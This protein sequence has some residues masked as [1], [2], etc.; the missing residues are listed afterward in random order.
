MGPVHH[1]LGITVHRDDAGFFLSQSQYA[2]DLLERAGMANCKPVGTPA[3][4]K[5]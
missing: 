4:I 2:E 5:S 3:D 1:F